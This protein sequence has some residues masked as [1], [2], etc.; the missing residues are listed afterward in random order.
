[1]S[2]AR[3]MAA[4]AAVAAVALSACTFSDGE[5]F[6]SV[7]VV[8]AAQL[9]RAA[10]RDAGD[11]WQRLAS[12]YQVRLEAAVL[13]VGSVDLVGSTGQGGG[14]F[15]PASPPPGYSLCHNGHCH[16]DDGRLVSYA[17]VAAELAGGDAAPVLLSIPVGALDLVAGAERTL[18]C[19]EGGG[20]TLPL[21]RATVVR[22][23]ATHL[24][25]TGQVR[26]G[27]TAA[28]RLGGEHAFTIDIPVAVDLT[29]TT[30]I[31]ADRSHA[32]DVAID[33]AL[34]GGAPWLDAL[35]FAA[36]PVAEGGALTPVSDPE[37]LTLLT[38]ALLESELS[39][40]VTR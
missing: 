38:T 10:G 24:V 25:L 40:V 36:A 6:A 15:D 2:R 29:A 16:A 9:D 28:P 31:A 3:R 7:D 22:V 1:M 8:L 32:P 11:G 34:I 30:D 5:P 39:V 4:V 19:A 37:S 20:C 35:D 12:D 33:L 21:G 18:P 23:R 17:D 27:R 13:T 26:D 14:A